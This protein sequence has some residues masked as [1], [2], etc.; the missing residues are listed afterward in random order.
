MLQP[1]TG[2]GKH[3][4]AGKGNTVRR[5]H[6]TGL[7]CTLGIGGNVSCC[8]DKTCATCNI[9]NF[10]FDM[11]FSSNGR[12]GKGLYA[13]AASSKAHDYAGGNAALAAMTGQTSGTSFGGYA[14]QSQPNILPIMCVMTVLVAA[15]KGFKEDS[16][17]SLVLG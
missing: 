5:F 10:G 6:G 12:Y 4:H 14:A 1:D 15:G 8:D 7:K 11:G 9:I 2:F 3:R 16:G 17:G 13:T